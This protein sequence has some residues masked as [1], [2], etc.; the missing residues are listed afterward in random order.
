M[1]IQIS[2]EQTG[3]AMG[4]DQS[5]DPRSRGRPEYV[6]RGAGLRDGRSLSSRQVIVSSRHFDIKSSTNFFKIYLS[7]YVLEPLFPEL[8]SS[9]AL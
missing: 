9:L 8:R 5:L 7:N 6:G 1:S 4:Y 2:A 3:Y